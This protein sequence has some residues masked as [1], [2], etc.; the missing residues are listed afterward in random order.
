M[1][2]QV[3]KNPGLNA[4]ASCKPPLRNTPLAVPLATERTQT[5]ADLA[6][7]VPS[8]SAPGARFFS[9][10]IPRADAGHSTTPSRCGAVFLRHSNIR[11]RCLSW[12]RSGPQPPLNHVRF[13]LKADKARICWA[14]PKQLLELVA[15]IDRYPEF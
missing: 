3:R 4:R 12:V 11:C 15:A 14:R 5:N 9:A 8:R 1:R 13:T 2:I 10:G 7:F 6:G